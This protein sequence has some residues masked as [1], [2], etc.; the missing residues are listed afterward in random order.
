[1]GFITTY[2]YITTE[3]NYIIW[4]FIPSSLSRYIIR[5]VPILTIPAS[6]Y[7]KDCIAQYIILYLGYIDKDVIWEEF[8]L[9]PSYRTSTYNIS[10]NNVIS[11]DVEVFTAHKCFLYI[12]VYKKIVISYNLCL[13]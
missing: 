7:I 12:I 3:K 10:Y 5:S 9:F 6:M 8:T 2:L 1:M 4:Y 11:A 13:H